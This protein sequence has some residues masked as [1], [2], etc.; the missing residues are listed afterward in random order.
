[1]Y[2]TF[3]EGRIEIDYSMSRARR[4]CKY[5]CQGI[6]SLSRNDH[7]IIYSCKSDFRHRYSAYKQFQFAFIAC[8]LFY[9]LI[10]TLLKLKAKNT[11]LLKSRGF[12]DSSKLVAIY[13]F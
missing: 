3:A 10:S 2:L 1:M 4:F 7:S 11:L 13:G 8:H 12:H 5:V 6:A 9:F